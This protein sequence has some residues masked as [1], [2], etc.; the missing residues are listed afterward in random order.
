G[1]SR[2]SPTQIVILHRERTKPFSGSGENGIAHSRS[3]PPDDFFTHAGDRFIRCSEKM[4]PDFRH[5]L[6][7][8]QREVV[9]I[10][11]DDPALLNRYLLFEYGRQSHND[12]HLC[13][14]LGRQWVYQEWAGIQCDVKSFGTNDSLFADGDGGHNSA[15][16]NF[17]PSYAPAVTYGDSSCSSGRE[18]LAPSGFLRHFIQNLDPTIRNR[19]ICISLEQC[20]PV[21]IG[22]FSGRVSELID[23]GLQEKLVLRAA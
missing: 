15:D 12:L 21:L 18:L 10:A 22:I 14:S 9:K 8:Q 23:E 2:L 3:H 20:A 4:N 1:P 17:V 5:F 6:T 11:L 7:G 19:K 16:G 13:L